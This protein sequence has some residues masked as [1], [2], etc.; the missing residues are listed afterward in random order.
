MLLLSFFFF[1]GWYEKQVNKCIGFYL[2]YKGDKAQRGGNLEKAITLYKQGLEKYPEHS[3]A[4]CNLGNIYVKYEDYISA[5]DEY[6]KALEYDPKFIVCRMNL[7]IVSAEKLADYDTAIREYQTILETNR[8]TFHIPLVY[9]SVQPTKDNKSIAWYN[10]GLAYRGK[11]LLMGEKTYASNQYLKKAVECY[12]KALKRTKKSF[13]LYYNY[14]LANHLLGN[15]KD[16][17]LAYC[18]AIEIE[19]LSFDAHYNMALLLKH[20]KKYREALDELEK[21]GMIVDTTT[22]I[23]QS[24]YVFNILNEVSQKMV[25]Q[26]E[27][28][29]IVEQVTDETAWENSQ[30]TYIHGKVVANDEYEKN[31]VKEFSKC[32]GKKI[33]EDAEE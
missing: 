17:G 10:M 28:K 13:D 20:L 31:M 3:L 15:Y 14:A 6:S 23:R 12:E 4:R 1:W 2:I 25:A 29:H 9:N 33:F 7:G 24:G 30:V 11:S 26:E 21:A 22:D 16:A 5:V 8:F 27:Y 18:K 32:T 19:P